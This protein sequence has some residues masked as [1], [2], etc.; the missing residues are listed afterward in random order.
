MRK[1]KVKKTK[2]E[3]TAIHKERW[4]RAR[5]IDKKEV[6]K[7]KRELIEGLYIVDP[8]SFYPARLAKIFSV[9]REYIR[10]VLEK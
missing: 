3:L 8:E 1:K 6:S 5:I 4:E 2:E 7:D 10:Q 9:S